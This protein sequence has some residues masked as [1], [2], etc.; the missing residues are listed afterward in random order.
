VNLEPETAKDVHFHLAIF[1]ICRN[2]DEGGT[3]YVDESAK[4]EGELLKDVRFADNQ[5]MV[6][7][8]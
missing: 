4:I 1:H 7:N 3:G 6:T 8:L 5:E 2:D